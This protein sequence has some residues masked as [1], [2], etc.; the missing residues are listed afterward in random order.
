M[1]DL[2]SHPV[3]RAYFPSSHSE[4]P[5]VTHYQP[6]SGPQ[7]SA[8]LRH[9][10]SVKSFNFAL[11]TGRPL[12]PCSKGINNKDEKIDH[13]RAVAGCS[14]AGGLETVGWQGR[15]APRKA[16]TGGHC[17]KYRPFNQSYAVLLNAYYAVKDALVAS[18]TTKASAAAKDL[19]NASECIESQ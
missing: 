4:T 16:E 17:R 1:L 12:T 9:R 13:R 10:N 18:D 11:Q 14:R 6:K 3:I 19:I 5:Q 7:K 8:I 15:N 2:G